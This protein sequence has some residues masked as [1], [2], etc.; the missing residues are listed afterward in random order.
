MAVAVLVGLMLL[1][2]SGV[3]WCVRPYKAM[4]WF[5]HDILGWHKTDSSRY[6][7]GCSAH[8]HCRF[9][10]KEIMQDGQG[11]WFTF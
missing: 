2:L 3:I 4:S 6:Y 1:W 7:D 11:N 10:G 8:S 5:Y 9:C